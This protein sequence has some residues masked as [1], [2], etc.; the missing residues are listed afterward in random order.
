MPKTKLMGIPVRVVF[1][2]FSISSLDKL[3]IPMDDSKAN[4]K[5]YLDYSKNMVDHF[6]SSDGDIRTYHAEE[7]NIDNIPT[8]RQLLYL[9]QQL[10]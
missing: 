7:Y 4:D 6:V 8:G 1:L 3:I 9:Y 2:I 10:T 5:K